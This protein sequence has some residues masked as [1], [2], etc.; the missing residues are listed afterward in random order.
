MVRW[1]LLLVLLVLLAGAVGFLA[2]GA[3]PP[4]PHPTAVHKVMPNDHL[5]RSN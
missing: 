1:F 5:G 2:L 4:E 3:F